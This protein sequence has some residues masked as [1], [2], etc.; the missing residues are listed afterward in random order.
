MRLRVL[1][2][3]AIILMVLSPSAGRTEAFA[4]YWSTLSHSERG[5]VDQIAAGIY[6]EEQGRRADS[7]QGLNSASKAR[8]RARA[9]ETLGVKNRPQRTRQKGKDI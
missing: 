3:A 1:V 8:Y 6:S 2:G 5:F 9:V 7:Y 4:S